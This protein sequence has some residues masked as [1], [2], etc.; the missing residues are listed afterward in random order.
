[1]PRQYKINKERCGK[2]KYQMNISSGY[3]GKEFAGKMCGY[4]LITGVCRCF[5]DGG[6]RSDYRP[7]YCQVFEKRDGNK[8]LVAAPISSDHMFVESGRKFDDGNE[9]GLY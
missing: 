9:E 4:A 3:S 1:M 5:K 7:G 8:R 6:Y 2:C